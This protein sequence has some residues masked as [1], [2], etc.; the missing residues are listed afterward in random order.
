MGYNERL[1]ALALW[2]LVLLDYFIAPWAK[3]SAGPLR[4][5][6]LLP[7][8]LPYLAGLLLGLL[9]TTSTARKLAA[10][11]IIAGALMA[12][13]VLLVVFWWY[14]LALHYVATGGGVAELEPTVWLTLKDSVVFSTVGVVMAI[15]RPR[16]KGAST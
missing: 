5:Y 2:A 10:L 4:G 1:Y 6:E 14:S 13:G 9:A 16:G 3:A 8:T 12:T 7:F 15:S 11:T